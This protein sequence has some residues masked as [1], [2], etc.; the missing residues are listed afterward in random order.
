[1][2]DYISSLLA[3]YQ[4]ELA[5]RPLRTKALT[6]C[7]VA[8]L[9]EGIGVCIR[10]KQSCNPERLKE[11]MKKIAVIGMYG[12]LVTGPLFHWWYAKLETLT[13]NVPQKY[14]LIVKLLLDRVVFTPPFLVVTL[15]YRLAFE[16]STFSEKVQSLKR[17]FLSVLLMNWKVWTVIQTI[18]LTYV[19]LELR[20]I[21]GNVCACAWN[22]YLAVFA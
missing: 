18:N 13:R 2:T 21:F 6:S 15:M 14:K 12:L 3:R 10:R 8:V 20:S 17:I 22:T 19:P 9:G 1:M 11:I 16:D 5:E 4:R 7:G